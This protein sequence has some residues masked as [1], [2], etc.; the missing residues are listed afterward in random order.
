MNEVRIHAQDYEAVRRVKSIM[1]KYVHYKGL[2]IEWYGDVI[3]WNDHIS[4]RAKVGDQ[5]E[6]EGALTE[7]G[8]LEGTFAIHF[9]ETKVVFHSNDEEFFDALSRNGFKIDA[10]ESG[11]LFFYTVYVGGAGFVARH[12][13]AARTYE[14]V[15]GGE[16]QLMKHVDVSNITRGEYLEYR[17]DGFLIRLHYN[18]IFELDRLFGMYREALMGSGA[19]LESKVK[20]SVEIRYKGYL[21]KDAGPQSVKM[22]TAFV[23]ACSEKCP[24][25]W[26]LARGEVR[27]VDGR[28]YVA[29][30]EKDIVLVKGTTIRKN[31]FG[32]WKIDAPPLLVPYDDEV[33]TGKIDEY[34]NAVK[35]VEKNMGQK[36]VKIIV[37]EGETVY[38][39]EHDKM[40]VKRQVPT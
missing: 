10:I 2:K 14:I 33:L 9:G 22:F 1:Q 19:V 5:L 24:G 16:K 35:I 11:P 15:K 18:N 31:L 37:D 7:D 32:K 40:V 20:G 28:T 12:R 6:F 3:G 26:R 25:D 39:L 29:N 38:I 23:D 8:A 30:L 21:V 13:P 4:G 34:S 36:V 27:I 17:S